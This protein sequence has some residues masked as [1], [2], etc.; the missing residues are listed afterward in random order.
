MTGPE[1]NQL[2][3]WGK[4]D[5]YYLGGLWA[6]SFIALMNSALVPA[7]GLINEFLIIAT[8]FYLA[9]RL[10][11]FR[12]QGRNGVLSFRHAGYF[13]SW[14]EI[15]ALII[16]GFAQF[17]YLTWWDDGQLP[18]ILYPILST[19]EYAQLLKQMGMT[20]EQY[21]KEVESISP[22]SFASSCFLVNL[23]ACAFMNIF[24]AAICARKQTTIKT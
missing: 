16:F 13:L 21:L 24:I 7:F 8:P 14:M 10:R 20:V 5:G 6:V 23:I 9:W 1:F 22:L 12:D 2:R 15:N 19:P 17:F 4:Y 11:R 18:K 3:V